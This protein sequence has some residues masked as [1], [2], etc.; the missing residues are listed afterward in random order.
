MYGSGLMIVIGQRDY[1]VAIE[2]LDFVMESGG[3]FGFRVRLND[4]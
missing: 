4:L 2:I 1:N 3:K